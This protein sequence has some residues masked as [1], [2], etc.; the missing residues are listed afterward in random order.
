MIDTARHFLPVTTIEK[1]IDS[2]AFAKLNCAAGLGNTSC[3]ST[4][5]SGPFA[6]TPCAFSRSVPLPCWGLGLGTAHASM[7]CILLFLLF[8]YYIVI[9]IINKDWRL[10]G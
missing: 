3:M 7:F 6:D 2:L 4:S 8:L 5:T 9:F 10:G 1:I